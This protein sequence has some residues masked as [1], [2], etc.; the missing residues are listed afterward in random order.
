MS[1]PQRLLDGSGSARARAILRAGLADAPPPEALPRVAAALGLGIGAV[2]ATAPAAAALHGAG[3]SAVV[4]VS[5]APAATGA[6]V[7]VLSKWL[8][9]GVLGG[10]LVSGAV[11]VVEHASAPSSTT[12]PG[13]VERAPVPRGPVVPPRAM[14]NPTPETPDQPVAPV[15]EAPA[16]V[17][18]LAAAPTAS[19]SGA[20]GV[21]AARIDAAR[22]ALARGDL[23]QT[24]RELDA[25][26][27]ERSVGVLDREAL[28]LRIQLHVRRGDR[29]R[30]VLLA[31]SYLASHPND[32]HTARLQALVESG[33]TIWPAPEGIER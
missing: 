4:A 5:K 13:V 1:E 2:A 32:A 20:L 21:E 7:A 27:R 10:A 9:A 29:D 6:S 3:A 24:A 17:S 15:A 23:E 8:A 19:Y 16:S 25:Y 26:Q 28:L 12:P 22:R 31:H 30:A 33:G 14:L 11:T 18:R